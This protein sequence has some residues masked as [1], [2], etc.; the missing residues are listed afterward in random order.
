ML[1]A[2]CHERTFSFVPVLVSK[3]E[4]LSS[5]I[6]F[7]FKFSLIAIQIERGAKIHM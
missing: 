4:T 2:F 5:N 7:H 1:E 3:T 6:V